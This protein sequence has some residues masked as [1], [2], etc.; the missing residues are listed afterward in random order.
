M[1]Q[2]RQEEKRSMV[3]RPQTKFLQQ[4]QSSRAYHISA[5][6]ESTLIVG[7]AIVMVAAM[8]VG[9]ILEATSAKNGASAEAG[10]GAGA[11]AESSSAEA[12]PSKREAGTE[13]TAKSSGSSSSSSERS[14]SRASSSSSS[15]SSAGAA[16]AGAGEPS[17]IDQVMGEV[18]A[19]W[20]GDWKASK[21]GF[22]AKNFYEGG[23]EDKMTRRE[24]ALILG[25]REN[26][27][28]QRI[29]ESHR[30]ILV[31]NHP[32]RGGSPYIAAKIN[33]AKDLLLKDK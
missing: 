28:E 8:G 4:L 11:G 21:E 1:D 23:F 16:G 25:V 17:Y 20:G 27:A 26:T 3:S 31:I 9:K 14:E 6:K 19:L 12:P 18:F 2:N 13:S 24:A 30:R 33:L 22:F 5:K 7:G 29:K 10:A 15:A 32:D